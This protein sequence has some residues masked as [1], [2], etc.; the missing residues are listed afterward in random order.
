MKHLHPPW[1]VIESQHEQKH[2]N[3]RGHNTVLKLSINIPV[4]SD[5]CFNGEREVAQFFDFDCIFS[6]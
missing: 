5:V 6:K 4:A 1:P 2:L 3:K